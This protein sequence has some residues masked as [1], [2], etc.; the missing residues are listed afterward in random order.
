VVIECRQ[1]D[2]VLAKIYEKANAKGGEFI[3]IFIKDTE[4]KAKEFVAE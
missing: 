3:G 4:L 1:E 2:P